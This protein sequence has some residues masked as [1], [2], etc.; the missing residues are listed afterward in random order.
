[1]KITEKANKYSAMFET[2]KRDNG[3]SFVVLK[4]DASEELR[5]SVREA[6]GEKL[7]DDW[8]YGTYADLMERVTEFEIDSVEQLEDARNEIVDNYVDIYTADLLKWLSDD[9]NNVSYLTEVLEEDGAKDGFQLLA[10][11]Q[12]KA[13]DEIFSFVFDLLTKDN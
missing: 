3:N 11:A 1:M 7:P 4:D 10:M 2:R 8:V 12:Y 5:E 9:I 6:H 13:I